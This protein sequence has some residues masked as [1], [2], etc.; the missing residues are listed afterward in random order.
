[1]KIKAKIVAAVVTVILAILFLSSAYTLKENEFGLI[2]EFGKVV[3]TKAEAGLY[4]KKPFIQSVM[5]LPK[6]E[7]LYDLAS[8]DVITSDKKSMIADCYVIWQIEDPLKYYQTL[9]STS[10]AESRID[11]LVYNSMK[12]VISSTKQ[13]E[14]I[15]GKDGTLSIKIMDNLSGKNSAD[16]YGIS[17]NS[18]EMKLLDLPSDNKDAVYSRMISE[19]NKIAAQY[20]AEGESQAQQIRNDVDYQVRVILSNAEKDAKSIIAEGEAE[21][22]KIIQAAYNSPERKDFYQFLRGLDATKASLTEGTMVII[23][24]EYKIID[25]LKLSEETSTAPA[26]PTEDAEE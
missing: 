15:Q 23:D 18:V 22:M 7:Q 26:L 5:K 21:Y 2:K 10:N 25:N 9:K 8:S 11:V 12:N 13:D 14:I 3:E 19:R 20:T 1:M 17:I 4:F 6:E 16:Q 24:D